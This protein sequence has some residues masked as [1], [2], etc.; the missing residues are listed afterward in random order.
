M[1]RLSF[2]TFF[3]DE[4]NREAY[5]LCCDV[6][7]LRT[8]SPQP[9]IILGDGGSGK[10]HLL[11]S[12]LNRV[13]AGTAKV[14]LVYTYPSDF[15]GRALRLVDDPSPVEH[16]EHAILLVDE[17][18]EF[19]ELTEELH[20]IIQ[21]FLD[22]KHYVLLGS[23]F[24]PNRLAQL[25]AGLRKLLTNGKLVEL[26]PHSPELKRML[27]GN[28][29]GIVEEQ[30]KEIDDLKARV[31]QESALSGEDEGL[32]GLLEKERAEKEELLEK[33]RQVT[34]AHALSGE[35]LSEGAEVPSQEDEAASLRVRLEA[36]E[37]ARVAALE[38]ASRLRRQLEE[39]PVEGSGARPSAEAL[40]ERA[41]ALLRQIDA[42]RDDFTHVRE[43]QR[44]QMEEWESIVS[45]EGLDLSQ[46]D[47]PEGIAGDLQAEF[48][49]A[50]AERDAAVEEVR[51]VKVEMGGLQEET[52][53]L[54]ARVAEL[55]AD[56]DNL[57]AGAGEAAALREALQSDLENA[58]AQLD[59]LRS[60]LEEMQGREAEFENLRGERDQA[61]EE[62]KSLR[63][64]AAAQVAEVQAHAGE[65]EG[66]LAQAQQARGHLE[67]VCSQTA[68][69][70]VSLQK[71]L[72]EAGEAAG[73][74]ATRLCGE[75]PTGEEGFE[76]LASEESEEP[77]DAVDEEVAPDAGD[78]GQE[79]QESEETSSEIGTFASD[80]GAEPLA[81]QESWP[82]LPESPDEM[83]PGIALSEPEGSTEDSSD[84]EPSETG[85]ED[86]DDVVPEIS[87][88]DLLEEDAGSTGG[89][90][91]PV[92]S[93]E[94]EEGA[95]SDETED[96]SG[97]E[98]EPEEVSASDTPLES[99]GGDAGPS[100]DSAGSE[101]ERD[102]PET[103]DNGDGIE[104]SPS[105]VYP[106]EDLDT[107]S[108]D[109]ASRI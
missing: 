60:R 8:V 91:I 21:I 66:L 104:I 80:N 81:I 77:G 38:E 17:L 24:H 86:A 69:E 6:A 44:K 39:E 35:E 95:F 105:S 99:I 23:R 19:S 22:H 101:D 42:D 12:V 57:A 43:E 18:E 37:S 56:N 47:M 94:D 9:V 83:P 20:K 5:D 108:E 75:R 51:E 61:R 7:E 52:R 93:I 82:P 102:E 11:Y 89:E 33:L 58:E 29:Q 14:G 13:R 68:A 63:M 3:V 50:L 85:R 16:A 59:T 67:G 90:E 41:D 45:S 54:Q 40:L 78:A 27:A 92:F 34:A 15:P 72:V 49:R 84:P 26:K 25:P 46:L 31:R 1:K 73:Q 98:E 96:F 103:T 88:D 65:L 71:Q 4:S 97:S 107:S 48:D 55:E 2:S 53:T 79:G 30:Q 87:V 10:T 100:V 70:L 106:L 64:E 36:A 28:A 74:L 109:D 32:Q 76:E 62:M